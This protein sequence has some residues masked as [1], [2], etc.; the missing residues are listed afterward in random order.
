M[1]GLYL[2]A[3]S[4]FAVPDGYVD[5]T[6]NMLEWTIEKTNDKL[7]LIAQREKV[8]PKTNLDAYV[9]KQTKNYDTVFEAYRVEETFEKER[10]LAEASHLAFRFK[11]EREVL[12]THQAFVL[13]NGQVLVFT[14][15]AKAV[16]RAR[17]DSVV[18]G[19]MNSLEFRELP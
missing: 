14:V 2:T 6:V 5:R 13:I 16:H 8:P 3:D 19:L 10:S 1:N 12:Y 7:S 4:A 17:G 15:S 18:E 9:A 11:R